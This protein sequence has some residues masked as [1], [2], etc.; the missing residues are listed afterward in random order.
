MQKFQKQRLACAAF[1]VV[2][3]CTAAAR[4]AQDYSPSATGFLG[5]NTAPN[6]R[7]DAPGTV[8][9]GV[10]MHDPY[11]HGYIGAQLAA[12][13][14]VNIR[15]SAKTTDTAESRYPGLD[16]K[17][18]LLD[19]T[20]RRPA[21]AVGLQSALG[22]KRTSGEYIT[23]SKRY[24]S[25]DFTAG[26]GWGAFAA[27]D[28]IDNPFG[29]TRQTDSDSPNSP[30]NWFSGDSAGFFGGM[31][32]FLPWEG[33][34][35]KLDYGTG[36][37]PWGAGLS[38]NHKGWAQA[39]IG[40]QD[41][42][43]VTARLSFR[44]NPAAWPF[45]YG[46]AHATP[47]PDAVKTDGQ[48]AY[49]T[50]NLPPY[51]SA[52][53]HIGHAARDM[54]AQNHADIRT[55]HITPRSGNLRGPAVEI[56]RE[57]VENNGITPQEIWKNT[58]FTTERA[59]DYFLPVKGIT[60]KPALMLT[61]QND[62]SLSDRDADILHRSALL[63][64]YESPFL[65]F[66]TGAAVRVNLSDNLEQRNTRPAIRPPVR[67]DIYDFSKNILY[68]EKA[69]IGYAHSF[70]P[71]IH[72]GGAAGYLEEFYGGAGGEILYRPFASR[73]AVGAELWHGF[74]RNPHRPFGFYTG[75]RT[76]T[77][78]ING[79]YDVPAHD[80]TLHAKAGRFLA[81]DLG[82]SLGVDKIFK[83]GA[84]LRSAVTL[85]N[86]KDR[87]ARGHASNTYHSVHLTLPLGGIP[88]IPA[89]SSIATTIAPLG[90][91][92]GQ[93][94]RSPLRLFDRTEKFTLDHM[95]TH[96]SEIME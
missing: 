90:R 19:E 40:V 43:N 17:V 59:V 70:T 47:A 79:W 46:K 85:G 11:M 82:L 56:M 45:T 39:Q 10:G 49:A 76:T 68:P 4:G 25:F 57:N 22:H 67:R 65:G 31:E 50:L 52:P 53:A 3:S 75:S 84:T 42:D 13:L 66:L 29:K 36:D 41:M 24:H 38:Y 33:L 60:G 55:F 8:R 28:H 27:A 80:V 81:G 16:V 63:A 95:A 9:A 87:D 96:W 20:A 5:L 51:G 35:L 54:A 58:D 93:S 26:L 73:L 74:R 91:D 30:R 78:H 12:P 21:V 2:L 32:Y 15:Q 1:C 94:L 77:A 61:L 23:L 34:S 37:S 62:I 44:S 18:R 88:H 48:N 71:D 83:N 72:I 6:A 14:Y 92:I 86:E 7:M 69:W 64:A 89:G